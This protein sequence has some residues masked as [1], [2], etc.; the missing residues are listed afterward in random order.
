MKINFVVIFIWVKKYYYS[1][2]TIQSLT[3]LFKVLPS[4]CIL[5]QPVR[6]I[7]MKTYSPTNFPSPQVNIFIKTTENRFTVWNYHLSGRTTIYLFEFS[8]INCRI[9]SNI[10]SKIT[11]EA[12]DVVL[13]SLLF[14]MHSQVWDNFW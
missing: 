10:C 1:H 11:M 9:K 7:K 13:V 2:N 12:P 8:N 14:K 5:L 3:Y 4:K 6:W